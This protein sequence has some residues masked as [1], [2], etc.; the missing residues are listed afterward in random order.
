M[1]WSTT[2]ANKSITFLKPT[3][4]RSNNC[5]ALT[6]KIQIVWGFVYAIQF[7]QSNVELVIC[8]SGLGEIGAR[9][10]LFQSLVLSFYDDVIEYR[11]LSIS[12]QRTCCCS[13]FILS[14]ISLTHSQHTQWAS[15][16]ASLVQW[17]PKNTMS[18]IDFHVLLYDVGVCVVL[19]VWILTV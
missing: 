12:V 18:P 7:G 13:N 6:Q 19:G 2:S 4:R 5:Q 17:R 16:F 1:L 3:S 14:Y 11:P 8:E 10:N 15:F 9:R